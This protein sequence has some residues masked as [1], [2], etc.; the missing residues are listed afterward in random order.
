MLPLL[1]WLAVVSLSESVA[2][3]GA[4]AQWRGP[5]ATGVAPNADPPLEWSET[6]NIRWKVEIPGPRFGVAGRLGRPAVRA[7]GRP[8][9]R[10]RAR[11]RTQPRGGSR[12]ATP[13]RFV[14]LAFDRKTGKIAWERTAREETPHEASHQD[15]G[16]WASSSAITDG[17]RVYR[18]LRVARHATPTTWTASCSGRR[19]SATSGCA[20]SSAKAAR[21][22]STAT[23]SSSSGITSAGR[24]SSSR[25]TSGPG[26]ELWRASAR[27]D[28]HLGH[29]AGRRADGRAQVIVPA[30]NK[31]RSYDLETGAV[32]WESDGHDDEPDSVA[33]VRRR[34]GLRDER[35]PG[36]QPQGDPARRREG[37]HHRHRRR[38]SG[39]SIATRR[40]CRR[41]CSTTAS[42]TS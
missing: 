8:V 7:D 15:N 6:K 39:R 33:G 40:T 19:T 42:S 25:S 9:G 1:F 38:S 22:R 5:L 27:R 32:V 37:R 2:D 28:R 24:R 29:A 21:R 16:T 20:T 14:V 10:H 31:V 13:H 18:L 17:E 3:P 30:M 11:P 4:W 41:R 34:A 26:K 12:R 36:Q 23:A 35:I